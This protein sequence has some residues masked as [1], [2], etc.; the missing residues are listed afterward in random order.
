MHEHFI[1][2]TVVPNFKTYNVP[3]GMS[4]GTLNSPPVDHHYQQHYEAEQSESRHHDQGDD[5]HHPT[6]PRLR[7]SRYV[8]QDGPVWKVTIHHE[9][10]FKR[11]STKLHHLMCRIFIKL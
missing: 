4:C 1:D 6:H 8:G 7:G 2:C 11:D 5:P 3:S 9:Y 10:M